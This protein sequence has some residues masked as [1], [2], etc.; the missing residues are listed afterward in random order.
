MKQNLRIHFL[1]QLHEHMLQQ[2]KEKELAE[3]LAAKLA[4]S[5][6]GSK[7]VEK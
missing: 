1:R 2:Q 3:E 7:I 5:D 4:T 6:K